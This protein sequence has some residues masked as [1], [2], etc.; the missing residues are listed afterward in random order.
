MPEDSPE[1][2]E[3]YDSPDSTEETSESEESDNYEE[4][5][6]SEESDENESSEND[7]S[8]DMEWGTLQ[9]TEAVEMQSGPTTARMVENIQATKKAAR[10]LPPANMS[11]AEISERANKVLGP[12][13]KCAG[14]T[15]EDVRARLNARFIR[16][17]YPVGTSDRLLADVS[18]VNQLLDRAAADKAALSG[19]IREKLARL[20]ARLPDEHPTK[21]RANRMLLTLKA[22]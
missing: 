7:D 10:R 13:C 1:S 9:T 16:R 3:S 18:R 5:E 2:S 19:G 15:P 20:A 17:G 14:L 12:A 11:Q 8:G 6:E 22:S 4:F 21:L